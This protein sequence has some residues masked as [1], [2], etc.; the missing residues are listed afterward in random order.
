MISSHLNVHVC[1]IEY[2]CTILMGAFYTIYIGYFSKTATIKSIYCILIIYLI[3][4]NLFLLGI[5]VVSWHN[6]IQTTKIH[7]PTFFSLPPWEEVSSQEMLRI[8][9]G[10]PSFWSLPL[11]YCQSAFWLLCHYW[12]SPYATDIQWNWLVNSE[13]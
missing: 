6:F 7:W 13:I 1:I 4:K 2:V 3:F 9:W 11:G 12:G 8:I 5:K 10:W